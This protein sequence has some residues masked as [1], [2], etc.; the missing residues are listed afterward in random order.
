MLKRQAGL[1]AAFVLATCAVDAQQT[2]QQKLPVKEH[3]FDLETSY[4]RMPL[5][6]GDEKYG[7]I[8]G[9]RLKEHVNAITGI[10]RRW[11]ESGAK[12][13]GPIARVAGGRADRGIYRRPLP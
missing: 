9:F 12:Y 10:T 13:L 3:T 7:R 5:Q 8:D 1:V 4:L 6:P 11:H 2:A